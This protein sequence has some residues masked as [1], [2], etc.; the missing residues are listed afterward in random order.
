LR[1][2]VDPGHLLARGFNFDG[3]RRRF[4]R[5]RF[6]DPDFA[7]AEQHESPRLDSPGVPISQFA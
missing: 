5:L 4:G 6:L 7:S 3:G 2:A 1:G